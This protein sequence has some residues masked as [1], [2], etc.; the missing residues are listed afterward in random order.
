MGRLPSGNGRAMSLPRKMAQRLKFFT[1]VCQYKSR[2][3]LQSLIMGPRAP[4]STT[5]PPPTK[6][7][8]AAAAPAAAQPEAGATAVVTLG[9]SRAA[10]GAKGA[11]GKAAP[12]DAATK[13]ELDASAAGV[14]GEAPEEPP[15]QRRK[16]AAAGSDAK[17]PAKSTVV[18]TGAEANQWLASTSAASVG[19]WED[20]PGVPDQAMQQLPSALGKRPGRQLDE[21]DAEYDRGKLKKVRSKKEATLIDSGGEGGANIFQQVSEELRQQQ[22]GGGR[23]GG[24]G[25]RHGGRAPGR[26]GGRGGGGRGPGFFRGGGGRGGRG[27]RGGGQRY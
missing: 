26:G 10:S 13:Q 6:A 27:G 5:P 25:G 4:S 3:R 16:V 7:P 2:L 8:P 14:A 20:V 1:Q 18:V 15:A 9:G 11:K 17:K 21:W 22:K 24:R 19:Q 23:G 12:V